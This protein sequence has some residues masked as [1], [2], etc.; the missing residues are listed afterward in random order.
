MVTRSVSL[1]AREAETR[2]RA[3]REEQTEAP[4][5]TFCAEPKNPVAWSSRKKNKPSVEAAGDAEG[6]QRVEHKTESGKL[7]SLP[8]GNKHP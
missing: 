2:I 5:G 7:R 4:V 8:S 3:L 6:R 1:L